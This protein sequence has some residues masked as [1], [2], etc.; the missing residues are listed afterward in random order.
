MTETEILLPIREVQLHTGLPTHL[1]TLDPTRRLNVCRAGTDLLLYLDG[2]T[3]AVNADDLA[4]ALHPAEVPADA[5]ICQTCFEHPAD[6][7][8]D[9]GPMCGWCAKGPDT[10]PE[11]K[12]ANSLRCEDLYQKAHGE[13]VR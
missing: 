3:W 8:T 2:K 6:R 12:R 11:W 4:H 10:E 7:E 13:G 1:F 9:I 5:P